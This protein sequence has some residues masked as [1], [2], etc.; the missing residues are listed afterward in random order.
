MR[1]FPDFTILS[2]RKCHYE[3][4]RCEVISG[5]MERLLHGGKARREVRNDKSERGRIYQ[6]E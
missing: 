2:R 5:F 3:Q 1:I 4:F 6:G